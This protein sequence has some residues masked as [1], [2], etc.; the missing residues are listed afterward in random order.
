MAGRTVLAELSATRSLTPVAQAKPTVPEPVT[1]TAGEDCMVCHDLP[2]LIAE[3]RAGYSHFEKVH[4]VV[5]ERA[6]DCAQC[7]GE[8]LPIDL[9][10]H[11]IDRLAQ[12]ENCSRCH[13][14]TEH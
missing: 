9:D 11:R 10:R 6:L 1:T 14:A 5:T 7:H 4:R 2:G 13:L 12:V 3:P 8:M